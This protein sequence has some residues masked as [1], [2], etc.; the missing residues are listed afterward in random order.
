MEV[1][2]ELIGQ[3]GYFAVFILLSLGIVGLPIP[4]EALMGPRWR[5]RWRPGAQLPDP[6]SGRWRRAWCSLP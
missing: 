3:Y 2:N 4:D 1:A 6:P 5:N